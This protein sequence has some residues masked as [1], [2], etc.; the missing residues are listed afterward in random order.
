MK[1]P[2][3]SSF[4]GSER[5]F[6]SGGCSLRK[7]GHQPPLEKYCWVIDPLDGTTNFAHDLPPYGV[8]IALQRRGRAEVGVILDVPTGDLF[9][10]RRGGGTTMNGH[11]LK[12]S[13]RA[14]LSRALVATGLPYRDFSYVEA[15]L[16]SLHRCMVVSRGVRRMGAASIDLAYVA[17]GSYEAFFEVDLRPWDVAAGI[18]T[19]EEAGGRVTDFANEPDP[20]SGRQVLASNGLV[21]RDM[22][23]IVE[24]MRRA[25]AQTDLA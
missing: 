4:A 5:D 6:L 14:P 25:M 8:S 7:G 2:K 21:H 13:P 3:P 22:M 1:P 23:S 15:Y 10:A 12:V 9:V 11:S 16:A 18:L 17:R 24:P 20:Y 19:V